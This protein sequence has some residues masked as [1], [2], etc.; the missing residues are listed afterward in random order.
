M[1]SSSDPRRLL[2][3]TGDYPH[4]LYTEPENGM[5][6]VMT[7]ELAWRLRSERGLNIYGEDQQYENPRLAEI[8][9]WQNA[10]F[11]QLEQ[12]DR[13][14]EAMAKAKETT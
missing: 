13:E 9:K 14:L 2:R 5:A 4:C 11:I 10:L 1:E 3:L 7:A 12:L 6:N 8:A